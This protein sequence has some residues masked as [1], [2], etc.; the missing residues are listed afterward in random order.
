MMTVGQTAG[1]SALEWGFRLGEVLSS[2]VA[3]AREAHT[4][5]VARWVEEHAAFL[6]RVAT[7]LTGVEAVAEELVQE[8]FLVAFRRRDDL[9]A[10]VNA[11]AWLYRVLS[12]M[13]RH[14]R[15]S[16]ARRL[17]LQTALGHE[18]EASGHR[19]FT[20]QEELERRQQA[21]LVRACV[22]KLPIKQREVFTLFEL[23]GIEGAE[24]ARLLDLPE[25]TVW[26]RLRHARERFRKLWERAARRG[27]RA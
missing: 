12:N 4:V 11:R 25:N 19:E 24:I 26:S 15:R 27:G 16:I 3:A 1:S 18:T 5:D 14:H 21:A 2:A 7:R 8:T 13:V 20:P 17:R 10:D 23:E 6:L 9:T 22:S